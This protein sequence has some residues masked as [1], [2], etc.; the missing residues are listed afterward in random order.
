M[1][2]KYSLRLL[3]LLFASY[4]VFAT[5]PTP[6]PMQSAT[7]TPTASPSSTPTCTPYVK[8]CG[9]VESDPDQGE[10]DDPEPTPIPEEFQPSEKTLDPPTMLKWRVFPPMDNSTPP[11]PAVLVIHGGNFLF[12]GLYGDNNELVAQDLAAKGYY[13]LIVNYRL[14]PCGRLAGQYGH[15]DP[16]SGRPPQQTDDIKTHIRAIRQDT[17]CNGKVGIVGA[18]AGGSHAVF[19][20]VD[21]TLSTGWPNWIASDRPEAIV[22]CSGAYDFSDRDDRKWNGD[23]YDLDITITQRKIENYTN[24][25]V[26]EEQRT[27]S[28]VALINYSTGMRPTFAINTVE[29]SMPWHQI[30]TLQCAL[31]EAGVSSSNYRVWSIPGSDLHAFHYWQSPIRDTDPVINSIRVR[32]RVVEFLDANLR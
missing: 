30:R 31:Q 21:K 29:D 5:L 2:L 10:V 12:G 14:A 9:G 4:Q 6:I 13:P 19:V 32:D 28:P 15:N 7:C 27:F 3:L 18:S 23:P 20:G 22:S 17:H 26:R 16:D 8:D 1:H 24:T 11:W 25:C